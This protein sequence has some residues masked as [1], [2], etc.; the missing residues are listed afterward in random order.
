MSKHPIIA[1]R[2]AFLVIGCLEAAWAPLVP[3]VKRAFSLDEASLGLLMLCTGLGSI[4]ALPLSSWLCVRFGAKRVVYF[5]GFLMA[6]SLLTISL[7]ANFTLTAIM[8]L[9]FGGCTITIDVAANVN[10]V[11][12]EDRKT[13]DVRISWGLF[14][15]YAHRCRCDE[16]SF[17]IRNNPYVVGRNIYDIGIG[18]DDGRMP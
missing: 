16:F 10:G 7:L 4:I 15:W 9:V 12:V 17:R 1:N 6:F 13:S 18:C 14:T 11:A 2:T 5:S 3:Y 8:L